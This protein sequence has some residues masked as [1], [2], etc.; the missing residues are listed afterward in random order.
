M[1]IGIACPFCRSPTTKVIDS[2]GNDAFNF[3]RRECRRCR[4]RFST[5]EITLDELNRLR[6]ATTITQRVSDLLDDMRT[7]LRV[8]PEPWKRPEPEPMPERS[9]A[10]RMREN[11]PPF[12]HGIRHARYR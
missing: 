9:D 12:H 2:R 7:E 1:S 11:H 5:H 3:R 6:K 10:V 8:A 4:K